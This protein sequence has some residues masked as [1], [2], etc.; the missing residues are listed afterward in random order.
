MAAW[1]SGKLIDP[2]QVCII[3]LEHF[4]Y[5]L[6]LTTGVKVDCTLENVWITLR[7]W[8]LHLLP[9]LYLWWIHVLQAIVVLLSLQWVTKEQVFDWVT[10]VRLGQPIKESLGSFGSRNH[11]LLLHIVEVSVNVAITKQVMWEDDDLFAAL[12]RENLGQ[13][14]YQRVHIFVVSVVAFHHILIQSTV[15]RYFEW[16][17]SSE[18]G[19]ENTDREKCVI[20]VLLLLKPEQLV[21]K[22]LE[23]VVCLLLVV[24]QLSSIDVAYGLF[25]LLLPHYVE[26]LIFCMDAPHCDEILHLLEFTILFDHIEFHFDRRLRLHIRGQILLHCLTG[27]LVQLFEFTESLI[28]GLLVK[29]GRVWDIDDC[30][31]HLCIVRVLEED[32]R[33]KTDYLSWMS[34]TLHHLHIASSVGVDVPNVVSD[35][36]LQLFESLLFVFAKHLEKTVG[37][38]LLC[39]LLG[40][41][42]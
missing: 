26:L 41:S 1:F 23:D 27:C 5:F 20:T 32:L 7:I 31:L 17:N 19:L 33:L 15:L 37:L 11:F 38:Q 39:L 29:I 8:A 6:W 18:T 13:R 40:E 24:F 25:D 42:T 35:L 21:V 10:L 28:K 34:R 22:A 2:T 4:C 14:A 36:S 3:A 30:V 12:I 9:V 16:L